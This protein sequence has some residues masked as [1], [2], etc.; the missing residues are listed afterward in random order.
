MQDLIDLAALHT[1]A[2]RRKLRFNYTYGVQFSRDTTKQIEKKVQQLMLQ[3]PPFEDP[4]D[5]T[6]D[7]QLDRS[8]RNL[9]PNPRTRPDTGGSSSTNPPLIPTKSTTHKRNATRSFKADKKKQK[10]SDKVSYLS[11]MDLDCC[12]LDFLKDWDADGSD[13]DADGS[14]R[15]ADYSDSD[16]QSSYSEEED[17]VS[18]SKSVKGKDRLRR[19]SDDRLEERKE[20]SIQSGER[21]QRL[22]YY[23]DHGI[24]DDD[25]SDEEARGEFDRWREANPW[26]DTWMDGEPDV[27]AQPTGRDVEETEEARAVSGDNGMEVGEQGGRVSSGVKKESK[28]GPWKEELHKIVYQKIT[29]SDMRKFRA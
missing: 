7:E 8:V 14:D 5:L 9:R 26:A 21:S 28:F 12:E 11:D 2:H 22:P 23:P 19:G 27:D 6:D 18:I 16:G 24:S 20:F 3:V 13:S 4:E 29:P 17:S 10:T 25:E 15:D 1:A